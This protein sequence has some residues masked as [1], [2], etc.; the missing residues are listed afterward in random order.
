MMPPRVE[1]I[2][3]EAALEPHLAAWDR[4]ALQ[5]PQQLPMLSGSWVL[6]QFGT[7]LGRDESWEC[8]LAF[9]GKELLGVLPLIRRH[10]NLAGRK[11]SL[12]RTPFDLHTRSGDAVVRNGYE[13]PVLGA[14]LQA[15]AARRPSFF[16]CG[17]RRIAAESPMLSVADW[18]TFHNLRQP[19]GYGSI[20]SLRGS[21][22]DYRNSLG[23]KF[24]GSLNNARNKLQKLANPVFSHV[25]GA[26][27]GEANLLA[28]FLHLEAGGWKG[29]QGSAIRL[30]PVLVH[31]YGELVRRLATNGWLEWHLLHANGQLIA[32]ELAVRCGRTLALVK[33]AYDEA[34][35]ACA[36]G[37]LLMLAIIE[38]AWQEGDTDRID[39][40]S[41]QPWHGH[42][43]LEKR[44]YFDLFLYPRRLFPYCAGYLPHHTYLRLKSKPALLKTVRQFKM[45]VQQCRERLG[46]HAAGGKSP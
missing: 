18:Q 43:K 11:I 23:S 45:K 21:L 16:A 8:C 17:W 24:R 30:D 19:A 9:D 36:P 22:G 2:T 46:S 6:A 32:A 29:K 7:M 4:L 41:D 15:V 35:A 42:W 20:L 33:M 10:K 1:W 26:A 44:K 5:A 13:A 38:R 12:L 37:N 14:L 25:A 34:F 31:F 39:C 40:L 28:D 3:G 27:A